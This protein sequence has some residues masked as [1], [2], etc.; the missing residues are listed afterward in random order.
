MFGILRNR[1]RQRYPSIDKIE[2]TISNLADKYGYGDVWLYGDYY[3]GLDRP[4]DH[5]QIMVDRF[6]RNPHFHGFM[7]ECYQTL[8]VNVFVCLKK[9]SDPRTDYILANSRMIHH[10]RDTSL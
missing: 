3:E 10:A 9:D 5:V 6:P 2:K 4:G 8:G 1:G 7:D